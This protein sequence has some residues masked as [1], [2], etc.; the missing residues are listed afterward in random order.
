MT[1]LLAAL[2]GAV[3]AGVFGLIVA[4]YTNKQADKRA[5]AEREEREQVRREDRAQQER[6]R[7][8]E[9]GMQAVH[10]FI[11]SVSRIQS[12][13][14]Y[15]KGH[16]QTLVQSMNEMEAARWLV[17]AYFPGSIYEMTDMARMAAL[18]HINAAGKQDG[19]T[20]TSSETL[21]G[22]LH[23]LMSALHIELGHD[24]AVQEQERMRESSD[25]E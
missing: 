5:T 8:H 19:D 6:K 22:S 1:E 16:S 24:F 14:F 15:Q 17:A 3:F 20:H 21:R 25:T 23:E 7:V 9:Q 13:A 18:A 10:R 2:G 4:R 11:T 12:G